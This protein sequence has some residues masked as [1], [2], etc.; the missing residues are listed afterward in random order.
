MSVALQQLNHLGTM[1]GIR[2]RGALSTAIYAKAL[3]TEN[4]AQ[5]SSEVLNLLTNDCTRLLELCTSIHYIW[6]GPLEAIAI[7][8]LL[9][10]LIGHWGLIALGLLVVLI[11]LQVW[12]GSRV[13][14]LRT[15]NIADTD[16]RVH[17]MHEIL[18]NIKLVKVCC[19]SVLV[20]HLACGCTILVCCSSCIPPFVSTLPLRAATV[21]S[22]MR[23][24]KAFSRR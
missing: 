5:H 18:Q 7:I 6:S 19:D 17:L 24:K 8:V 22:S 15:Q 14:A 13:A 2:V 11:A 23:G 10:S 12:I 9:I 4:I 20:L 21:C 1:T 16:Q 3:K